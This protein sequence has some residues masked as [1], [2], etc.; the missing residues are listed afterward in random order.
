MIRIIQSKDVGRLLKRRTAR[1][2]EAEAVV[3]PILDDVRK[4]GDSAL[5]EYARKFDGLVGKT[6]RIGETV[7]LN[8]LELC[9]PCGYL[10][11]RTFDG[12]K[13]ALK[14]RGGLRC[15]VLNGGTLRIGDD[16]IATSVR[17]V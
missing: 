8:G 9:E 11:K 4:R 6:F 17:Q 5:V 12:I 13:A 14:H 1:L 10:E 3:R 15:C 7:V 2:T 16:V